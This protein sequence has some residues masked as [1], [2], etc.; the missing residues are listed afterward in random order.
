MASVTD[1]DEHLGLLS[2]AA[3]G[4]QFSAPRTLPHHHDS[5][6]A[7]SSTRFLATGTPVPQ[8]VSAR[9]GATVRYMMCVIHHLGLTKVSSSAF[10]TV[11]I[12]YTSTTAGRAIQAEFSTTAIQCSLQTV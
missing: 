9:F 1:D 11:V 6:L 2:S 4:S 3:G 5:P 8:A 12:E 7:A 10:N